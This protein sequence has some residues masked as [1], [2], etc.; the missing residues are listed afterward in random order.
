MQEKVNGVYQ[1][2]YPRTYWQ[3]VIGADNQIVTVN[4]RISTVQANLQGQ[5]NQK[6]DASTAINT[7]NMTI[8]V[9]QI[10]IGTYTG[11][12]NAVQTID[13]PFT[14]QMVFVTALDSQI[15]LNTAPH[16]SSHTEYYYGGFAVKGSAAVRNHGGSNHTILTVRKNGFDVYSWESVESS[17]GTNVY[18]LLNEKDVPRRYIAMAWYT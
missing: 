12:G 6:Q 16:S 8:Y 17:Y 10:A 3:Q 11:N 13:L 2:L 1:P 14:P 18:S 4:N 15:F 9:P 7:S 5:I